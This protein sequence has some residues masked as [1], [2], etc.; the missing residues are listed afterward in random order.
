MN[1]I[2]DF[3]G[4]VWSIPLHTKSEACHTLQTWHKAITVQSGVT[5]YTLVTNNG[6]LLSNSMQNQCKSEVRASIT[7]SPPPTH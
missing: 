5:L 1:V 6:E 2:D 4:Y 7:N 3:L